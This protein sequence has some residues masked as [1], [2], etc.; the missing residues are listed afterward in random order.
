MLKQKLALAFEIQENN[1]TDFSIILGLFSLN[2]LR[3]VLFVNLRRKVAFKGTKHDRLH[4]QNLMKFELS[5]LLP[6]VFNLFD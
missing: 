5:Q 6:S 1:G 3:T 4:L 2:Y